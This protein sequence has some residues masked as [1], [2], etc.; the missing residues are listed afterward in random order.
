MVGVYQGIVPVFL[1]FP[2]HPACAGG[3]RYAAKLRAQ[4][5]DMPKPPSPDRSSDAPHPGWKET[6]WRSVAYLRQGKDEAALAC[7]EAAVSLR[8]DH[9]STRILLGRVQ[10]GLGQP[11]QACQTL[12]P[13]IA[14]YPDH[15]SAS[16]GYGLALFLAGRRGH[17][18]ECFRRLAE[19]VP[20]SWRAWNSIADITPSEPERLLALQAGLRVLLDLC[21]RSAPEPRHLIACV[22]AYLNCRDAQ[23]ARRFALRHRA[24]FQDPCRAQDAIARAC[25][26]SGEFKPACAHKINS[27]LALTRRHMPACPSRPR[28]PARSTLVAVR[29]VA[30]LMRSHGYIPVAL[31]GTQLGLSR[32]GAPLPEDRD[33]DIGLLAADPCC[34]DPVDIVRTHPGLVL[35]RHARTGDRYLPVSHKGVSLDL[36]HL[37]LEDDHYLYGFSHHAGD[38]QWRVARFAPGPPDE[39]GLARLPP[40][41]AARYLAE[42]YGPSWTIPDPV[43]ASAIASP[44]LYQVSPHAR[45]YYCAHRARQ[46]LLQQDR[47]KALAL[48]AHAPVAIPLETAADPDLWTHPPAAGTF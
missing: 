38:I 5:T 42:V 47:A 35:N 20:D 36:F 27:L 26:F 16:L 12:E 22:D 43:F 10:V 41:Q 3:D 32:S 29:Q 11:A 9:V 21:D 37:T 30:H 6:Y 40:A 2:T 25:Y 7:L 34:A 24:A 45:A 4:L 19:S 44:A 17:A 8:P 15:E 28:L 1:S 18:L 13:V 31:A 46:C 33:V 14:Q 39:F 48:L 23:S